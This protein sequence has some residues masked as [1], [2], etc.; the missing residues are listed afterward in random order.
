MSDQI[1][2]TPKHWQQ[3]ES[4]KWIMGP[5]VGH[6]PVPTMFLGEGA[7]SDPF[8]KERMDEMKQIINEGGQIYV[9][10]PKGDPEQF[11]SMRQLMEKK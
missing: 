8:Q 9:F 1:S 3:T 6:T 10:D 4:G 11:E 7:A 2:F 5:L